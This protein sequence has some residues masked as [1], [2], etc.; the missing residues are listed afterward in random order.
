MD[1]FFCLRR[2]LSSINL[3]ST[4]CLWVCVHIYVCLPLCLCAHICVCL[5]VCVHTYVF[6]S[7]FVFTHMWSPLCLC[8]FR[9]LLSAIK[10]AAGAAVSHPRLSS[11]I[12]ITYNDNQDLWPVIMIMIMIIRTYVLLFHL[13]SDLWLQLY[14]VL[15]T[16]MKTKQKMG[17]FRK[18]Q[19][20]PKP[21]APAPHH[22]H[23]EVLYQ[24]DGAWLGLL[25]KQKIVNVF[26]LT[27]V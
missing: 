27:C 3:K 25:A 16:T 22:V 8:V 6:A 15:T 7:V 23:L 14:N 13:G 12:T 20:Y 11:I 26:T 1:A 21:V 4:L 18:T 5:C 2:T 9:C 10:I 17:R 19:L 24:P